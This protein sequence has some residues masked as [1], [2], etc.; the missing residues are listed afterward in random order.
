[1]P[2]IYVIV[3]TFYIN[4]IGYKKVPDWILIYDTGHWR[5]E[6]VI[7]LYKRN[8]YRKIYRNKRKNN[9]N[10]NNKNPRDQKSNRAF[11]KHMIRKS[12]NYIHSQ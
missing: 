3:F 5:V 7:N 9:N 1:M 4:F 11:K 12:C 8:L 2:V 6:F 10:N